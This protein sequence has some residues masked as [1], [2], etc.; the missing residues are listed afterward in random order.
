MLNVIIKFS[1]LRPSRFEK[2][3]YLF[4]MVTQA[5]HDASFFSLAHEV[6]EAAKQR[7][8]Q[9]ECYGAQQLI[10]PYVEGRMPA[11]HEF[12]PVRCMSISLQAMTFLGRQAGTRWK[13]VGAASIETADLSCCRS[14]RSSS[15]WRRIPNYVPFYGTLVMMWHFYQP[16]IFVTLGLVGCCG[17]VAV[18]SPKWFESLAAWGGP[19]LT[20]IAS[21]KSLTSESTSIIM[22]CHLA[23]CLDLRCSW[24]YWCWPTC[25]GTLLNRRQSSL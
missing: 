6:I 8:Q 16:V 17:L 3:S 18:V 14:H 5:E 7:A 11:K 9:R 23:V 10:A 13:A 19:G 12:R 25:L 24:Q 1:P 21:S 15:R 20:P 4:C 2:I 22:F